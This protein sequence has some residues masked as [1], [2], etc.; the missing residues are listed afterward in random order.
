LIRDT[1]ESFLNESAGEPFFSSGVNR[2][3]SRP[4]TKSQ[5]K[6]DNLF[7]VLAEFMDQDIPFVGHHIETI[8]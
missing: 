3:P 4:K 7:P 1:H 5:R 6:T 2:N 8:Y